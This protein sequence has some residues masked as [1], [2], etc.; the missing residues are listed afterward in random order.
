MKGRSPTELDS[1][2][3]RA[4]FEHM[5]EIHQTF[6]LSK[7]AILRTVA[8]GAQMQAVLAY[9]RDFPSDDDDMAKIEQHAQHA[10]RLSTLARAEVENDFPILHGQVAVSLWGIFEALVED[11]LIEWMELVPHALDKPALEKIK[12]PLSQFIQY[13]KRD[14]CELILRELQRSLGADAA[15]G[16]TVAEKVLNVFGLVPT[17]DANKRRDLFELHNVRNL[18]VHRGSLV[19]EKF[20]KACPWV[21]VPRGTRLQLGSEDYGRYANCVSDYIIGVFHKADEVDRRWRRATNK[22]AEDN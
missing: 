6:W 21:A 7:Q 20:V 17:V 1:D 5:N 13:E 10:E 12:L 9:R 18:I 19:D 4:Q 14:Q 22:S 3:L 2:L 15:A 11:I 16:V 8:Y